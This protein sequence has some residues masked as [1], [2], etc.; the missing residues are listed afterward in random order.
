[1]SRETCLHI[2]VGSLIFDLDDSIQLQPGQCGVDLITQ[3]GRDLH[4]VGKV[5]PLPYRMADSNDHELNII[6]YVDQMAVMN[7]ISFINIDILIDIV[8]G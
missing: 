5:S 4:F 1:M 8:R 7:D 2:V 3:C 6:H